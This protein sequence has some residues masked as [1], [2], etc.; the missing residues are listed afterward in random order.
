MSHGSAESLASRLRG[1][2]TDTDPM[3]T[4]DE[5]DEEEEIP[6]EPILSTR[7]HAANTPAGLSGHAPASSAVASLEGDLSDTSVPPIVVV[8]LLVPV[9]LPGEDIE[10]DASIIDAIR[11]E[12]ATHQH[13]YAYAPP[14]V[15]TEAERK[16]AD[17]LKNP[18]EKIGESIEK[19]RQ[20]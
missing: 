15:M 11:D 1:D 7:T 4:L 12:E 9:A 2:A 8:P 5:F 10:A 17:S 13:A 19:V 3:P 14:H 20:Q 16:I 18:L 6:D